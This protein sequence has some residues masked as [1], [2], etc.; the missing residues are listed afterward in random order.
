V[1][2]ATVAL[3]AGAVSYYFMTVQLPRETA[4]LRQEMVLIRQAVER[5]EQSGGQARPDEPSKPEGPGATQG[6]TPEPTDPGAQKP[7]PE[8]EPRPVTAELRPEVRASL[9]RALALLAGQGQVAV[10]LG[11]AARN[12]WGTA[13]ATAGQ[14]AA[15]WEASDGLAQLAGQAR[16][17]Q[18]QLASGDIRGVARLRLLWHEAQHLFTAEMR[19]FEE[20][21]TGR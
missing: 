6:E 13:A 5:L 18:V 2:A 4:P 20:L 3:A 7:D 16:D 1:Y 10:A 12:D 21:N 11:D 9:L 15:I 14:A 8:P 17:C 19:R